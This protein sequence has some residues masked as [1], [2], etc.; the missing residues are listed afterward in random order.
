[1]T[2]ARRKNYSHRVIERNVGDATILRS[3][4]QEIHP[5]LIL[6]FIITQ[7]AVK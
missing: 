1:M 7:F 6:S 2:P 3:V 5:E 4:R